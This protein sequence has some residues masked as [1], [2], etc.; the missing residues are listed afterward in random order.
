MDGVL[1]NPI[2]KGPLYL[3][4]RGNFIVLN[5]LNFNFLEVVKTKSIE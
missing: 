1:Q 5:I 2:G 4:L 3:K